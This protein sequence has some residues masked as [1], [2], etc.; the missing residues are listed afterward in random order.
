MEINKYTDIIGVLA[1]SDIKEGRMVLL[2]PASATD[3]DYNY[4]SRAEL[5][6][7]KLP[8]TAA[9]AL[10]AKYVAAFS[11]DNRPTPILAGLPQYTW[12]MR[13]GGWDQVANLPAT[14][15]TLYMDHPG[16]MTVVQTIPSGSLALA[17]D[18]GV[19]TVTSGNFIYSAS[20]VAGAALSVAYDATHGGKLQYAS[21]G[22]IGVVEHFD[23]TNFTLT[24]RTL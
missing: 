9:E 16:N 20:L 14:S 21:D 15:L 4:G 11:L 19:F 7:I 18:K 12:S 24:F 13:S 22:T 23:S 2:T 5:M 6:G 17:F 10:K 3:L 8:E 1:T